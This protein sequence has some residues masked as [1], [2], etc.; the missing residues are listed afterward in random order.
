M[1]KAKLTLIGMN[2]Y[3]HQNNM[4]LFSKLSLPEGIEKSTFT[5]SVLLR[6]GE[7]EVVYS[8]P[9]FMSESIGIWGKKWY[10]VF[11]KW[12]DAL[13]IEYAPL[14]N[15]NRY[16][17]F[18]ETERIDDDVVANTTEENTV[19]STEDTDGELH[20]DT[21]GSATS[22]A[23]VENKVSAYNS[24]V[25]EPDNT[26]TSGS[27]GSNTGE[28]DMTNSQTVDT[29]ITE[30]KD[31]DETSNRDIDRTKRNINHSHGNIGVT[32]SQ[33]MLESELEIAYWNIYEKMSDIFIRELLVPVYS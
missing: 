17:D 21:A 18:L 4:D 8:D 9:I 14:E 31:K 27:T 20:R 19:N 1:S 16:D 30:N 28:E 23:S 10:R 32:T 5:N 25:Y 26:N 7:F 24:S 11:K 29:D 3:M 33:R 15:Y 6:G 2:T 12:I 13:N 22:S